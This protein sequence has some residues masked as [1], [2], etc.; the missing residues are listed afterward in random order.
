[1]GRHND[2]IKSPNKDMGNFSIFIG[3]P[4][5]AVA[6]AIYSI[7]VAL[8]IAPMGALYHTGSAV[9]TKI[10][11]YRASTIRDREALKFKA[12]QHWNAAGA[13]LLAPLSALAAGIF[14]FLRLEGSSAS[15]FSSSISAASIFS[16]S[17]SVWI[18]IFE[19]NAACWD[20]QNSEEINDTGVSYKN[21]VKSALLEREERGCAALPSFQDS[22]VLKRAILMDPIALSEWNKAQ[23]KDTEFDQE[24]GVQQSLLDTYREVQKRLNEINKDTPDSIEDQNQV[25]KII[26]DHLQQV[27]DLKQKYPEQGKAADRFLKERI[28]IIKPNLWPQE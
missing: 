12:Q 1:M 7:G 11:S 9:K 26:A 3:K 14:L 18:F 25:Q 6:R 5:R 17:I 21:L 16:S 10:Q 8:L 22:A 15:I 2:C 13:D 20:A 24:N 28:S 23:T 19:P 27:E 4:A